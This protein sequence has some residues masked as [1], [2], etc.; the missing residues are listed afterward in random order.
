VDIFFKYLL[1]SRQTEFNH[2]AQILLSGQNL[3]FSGLNGSGRS[4][5]YG[6][7]L[8]VFL[9]S[10]HP[11]VFALRSFSCLNPNFPSDIF[12]YKPQPSTVNLIILDDLSPQSCLPALYPCWDYLWSQR[13][14]NHRQIV[15]IFLSDL[16]FD[17]TSLSRLGAL[18]LENPIPPQAC[19]ITEYSYFIRSFSTSPLY[20]SRFIRRLYR[21]TNANL[22]LTKNLLKDLDSDHSLSQIL[23]NPSLSPRLQ[24]YFSQLYQENSG[25]FSEVVAPFSNFHAYFSTLSKPQSFDSHL[26]SLEMKLYQLLLQS[27]GDLVTR[28]YIFNYLWGPHAPSVCDHSLDQ[29]AYR[30]KRKLS[31]YHQPHHLLTVK[32]RGFILN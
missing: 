7:I 30:L 27:L 14:L 31:Q 22:R 13:N 25:N 32:G 28:D 11:S 26:T 9:Q 23:S 8:P 24:Y 1:T 15:F 21:L 2:L 5:I 29:L 17:P 19:T 10:H 20:T 3:T 6:Q 12:D 16:T 4:L 18:Y